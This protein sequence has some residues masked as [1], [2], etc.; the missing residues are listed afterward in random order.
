[1]VIVR[2]YGGGQ[3]PDDDYRC[4]DDD[5]VV[6]PVLACVGSAVAVAGVWWCYLPGMVIAKV[7]ITITMATTGYVYFVADDDL[8][9]L[10]LLSMLSVVMQ[11]MGKANAMD[12]PSN[13]F[14]NVL[15][16]SIVFLVIRVHPS[17]ALKV[18]YGLCLCYTPSPSPTCFRTKPS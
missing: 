5:L 12:G 11:Y 15:C 17:T 9:F 1:M 14:L 18:H 2:G 13:M 10:L 3:V 8:V 16:Y 6:Q 7:K 4:H